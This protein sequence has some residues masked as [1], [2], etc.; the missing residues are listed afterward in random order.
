MMSFSM[1]EKV[2]FS[3][4]KYYTQIKQVAFTIHTMFQRSIKYPLPST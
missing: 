4:T 1:K 2:Y 3:I